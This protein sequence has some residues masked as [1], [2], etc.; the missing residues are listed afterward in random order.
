MQ[1]WIDPSTPIVC[2]HHDHPCEVVKDVLGCGVVFRFGRQVEL[3]EAYDGKCDIRL[4]VHGKVQELAYQLAILGVKV[5]DVRE[6]ISGT[7]KGKFGSIVGRATGLQLVM[8][9]SSNR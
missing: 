6:D 4:C 5:V 1:Y 7:P 8:L 9:C 3:R 2:T